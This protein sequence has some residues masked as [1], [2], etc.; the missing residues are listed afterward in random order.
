MRNCWLISIRVNWH[1][2]GTRSASFDLS[3]TMLWLVMT[4]L[5]SETLCCTK[6]QSVMSLLLS[7]ASVFIVIVTYAR[8]KVKAAK[9]LWQLD[10][11]P[12]D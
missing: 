2:K 7:S 1:G 5:V 9:E 8:V 6:S 4:L 12:V 10:T 3:W 11:E